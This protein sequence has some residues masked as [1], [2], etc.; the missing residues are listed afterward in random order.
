MEREGSMDKDQGEKDQ[1]EKPGNED[2]EV[3]IKPGD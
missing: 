3:R 1:G 2:Q